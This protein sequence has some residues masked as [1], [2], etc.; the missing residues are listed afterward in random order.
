MRKLATKLL[1]ALGIL[2]LPSPALAASAVQVS[3]ASQIKF[4]VSDNKVF[5][6]NLDQFDSSW[7]SCC[8]NYWFDLTTETGKSH[9][10]YFLLRK[11]SGEA[12]HFLVIDK[13]QPSAIHSVG[14]F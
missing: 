9:Y 6:R 5:L 12:I 10:A 1:A 3:D 2:S 11:A 14:D 7:L 4:L 8:Y 13:T